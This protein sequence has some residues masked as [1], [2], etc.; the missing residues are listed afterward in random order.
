M[1]VSADVPVTV[2]AELSAGFDDGAVVAVGLSAAVVTAV[3]TAKAGSV[4]TVILADPAD[5]VA[6]EYATHADPFHSSTTSLVVM[7]DAV[8]T[9]STALEN[10]PVTAVPP[11]VNVTSNDETAPEIFDS[12]GTEI[13]TCTFV[14]N[15]VAGTVT[16]TV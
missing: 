6:W 1:P 10:V 11:T 14:V 9:I 4:K 15:S 13:V 8:M 2:A 12:V 16:V 5:T 3:P 7:V